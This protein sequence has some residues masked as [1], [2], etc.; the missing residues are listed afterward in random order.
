MSS[1]Y[2]NKLFEAENTSLMRYVL[3]LRLER[4]AQDLAN[5]QC[6]VLRVSDIALRWGFNDMSHFSRVFRERFAMSPRAWREQGG[7]PRA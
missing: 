2:I 1:R 3:N 6:A 4:C 5:P 7:K